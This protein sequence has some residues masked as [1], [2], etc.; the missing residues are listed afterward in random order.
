M[1]TFWRTFFEF[2]QQFPQQSPVAFL[3][4]SWCFSLLFWWLLIT[5]ILPLYNIVICFYI[6]LCLYDK[7]LIFQ[8]F[9]GFS[10]LFRPRFFSMPALF[11]PAPPP[12]SA[13]IYCNTLYINITCWKLFYGLPARLLWVSMSSNISRFLHCFRASWGYCVI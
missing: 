11:F 6:T 13:S 4:P 7:S 9:Q 3:V 1:E 12:A 10:F 5:S 2:L 8:Y